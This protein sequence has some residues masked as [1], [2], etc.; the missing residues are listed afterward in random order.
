M[1]Q[2]KV[3]AGIAG[4]GLF[5]ASFAPTLAGRQAGGGAGFDPLYV[6]GAT[7]VP[8]QGGRPPLLSQLVLAQA[9]TKPFKPGQQLPAPASA[10]PPPLYTDLG[11][12]HVPISTA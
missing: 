7:C 5:L 4:I 1:R 12:L 6:N 8:K 3:L 2:P 11:K 10:G 9:E